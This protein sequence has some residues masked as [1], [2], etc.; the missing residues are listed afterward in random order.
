MKIGISNELHKIEEDN[1]RE[2]ETL[3]KEIEKLEEMEYGIK[4]LIHGLLIGII[5]GF[6]LAM[7]LLK[8]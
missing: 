7:F 3:S 2:K 1:L 4:E 5:I 6:F 8:R